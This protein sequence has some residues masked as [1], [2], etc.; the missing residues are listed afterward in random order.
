MEN[1]TIEK[2]IEE[3]FKEIAGQFK[4]NGQK[5]YEELRDWARILAKLKIAKLYPDQNKME[6][7]KKSEAYA[8]AGV[9]ALRAKYN[10]QL[11]KNTWRLIEKFLILL[12][13]ILL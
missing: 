11:E 9:M 8:W 3:L 1:N 10:Q 4:E 12:K 13:N 5:A 6:E 7:L 2:H